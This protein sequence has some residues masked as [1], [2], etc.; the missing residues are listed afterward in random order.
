FSLNVR[1]SWTL[2]QSLMEYVDFW[3]AGCPLILMPPE[4]VV[5]FGDPVSVNCTTS[6]TDAQGMGWEAPSGGTGFEKGPTVTWMVESL[7]NWYILAKCYITRNNGDQCQVMPSITL[8]KTPDLVSVTAPH[9]GPMVENTESKLICKI[10]NVAPVQNL[11]VKWYKGNEVV[12]TET[13]KNLSV[14]PVNVTSTLK[15]TPTKEYDGA[16][17]KCDAELHL[18]PN[19]PEQ[20]PATSSEPH[21]AVEILYLTSNGLKMENPG[22]RNPGQGV[23]MEIIVLKQPTNMEQT[24]TNFMLMS[25][26][27]FNF[28]NYKM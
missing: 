25:C 6:E 10:T 22:K 18:G 2:G 9:D 3:M 4:I 13:F 20:I 26:V 24:F 17:F 15:V 28:W 12:W 11:T 8:Y 16:R 5:R 14:T 1:L 7:E 23:I 19:G 27:S 21:V